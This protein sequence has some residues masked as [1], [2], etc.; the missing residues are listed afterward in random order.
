MEEVFIAEVL[1]RRK[2][3]LSVC[4]VGCNL[5]ETKYL[6]LVAEMLFAITVDLSQLNILFTMFSFLP[7]T[8]FLCF[9]SLF[10]CFFF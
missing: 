9:T 5:T 2:W 8:R 1:V 10:M 4:N 6:D 3:L 7:V